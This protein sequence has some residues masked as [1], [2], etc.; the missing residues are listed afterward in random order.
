ML[1]YKT[2][3]ILAEGIMTTESIGLTIVKPKLSGI[4]AARGIAAIM[5]VF[6]HAARHLKADFGVLPWAGISQFG[7]AGVDFFF[8][9]SGF[10]IFFVHEKDLGYR[11]KLLPYFKRRFTRIYPLFWI[12]LIVGVALSLLSST[13]KFKGFGA[14]LQDATLLPIGG[15]VGVAWTLQHEILFYL[16]FAFAMINR[17][18]G[19]AVFALWLVFI[20]TTWT[21]GSVF[22]NSPA[23]ARLASTFNLEFF[24]GMLAAYVVKKH[25]VNQR[26]LFLTLGLVGF[27][28]FAIAENIGFFDGYA[29]SAQVAYGIS[30]M[31]IVIG[32]A[33]ANLNGLLKA[34]N[35]FTDLGSASYS[36]YLLHLPCI[37][38][39]YKLLGVAGLLTRLPLGLLYALLATG[40]IGTCVIIS[41]L[42]EYPLMVFVRNLI[43]GRSQHAK[44]L[45]QR[46]I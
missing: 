9:L 30:S 26:Y 11:S 22:L 6:Y 35:F 19:I 18:V 23:L 25:V 8:V 29:S 14:I 33:S 12:S 46:A 37:G 21:S 2:Q 31:L 34:P 32:I 17:R 43:S 36:I 3:F 16:I 20:I 10:I 15:E 4:E 40:A 27:S 41:R 1:S 44:E 13:Q 42:I 38:I 45:A 5:V 28:A 24:F 7:H 39:I